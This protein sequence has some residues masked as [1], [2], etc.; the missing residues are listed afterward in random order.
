[1]TLSNQKIFIKQFDILRDFLPNV[2]LNDLETI[3]FWW[4]Y[5]KSFNLTYILR[6]YDDFSI[7]TSVDLG[8]PWNRLE[9]LIYGA[10]SAT[11][12]YRCKK[13][14]LK[15]QTTIEPF[16]KSIISEYDIF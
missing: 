11:R 2:A 12:S 7:L 6:A 5:V 15:G 14:P 1:M 4:G 10:S 13:L 16:K 3:F 9:N 8:R